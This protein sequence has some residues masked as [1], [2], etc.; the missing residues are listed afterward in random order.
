MCWRTILGQT[1]VWCLAGMLLL[2]VVSKMYKQLWK[3][4]TS[5]LSRVIILVLFVAVLLAIIPKLS[6]GPGGGGGGKKP[7]DGEDN[8]SALAGQGSHTGSPAAVDVNV[9]GDGKGGYVV[10]VQ[11]QGKPSHSP[12]PLSNKPAF[13]RR[14]C[15]EL[16]KLRKSVVRPTDNAR[17]KARV[18]VPRSFPRLGLTVVGEIVASQD[19][20]IS[21]KTF[22]E[23]S[24]H[25][26]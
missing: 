25:A 22:G 7:G 4:M 3:R 1:V 18:T 21:H 8:A 20:L 6:F 26:K 13:R 15:A 23:G 14:L 19:Y 2:F 12:I 17:P 9:Y 11:P 5:M 24:N 10:C 16:A